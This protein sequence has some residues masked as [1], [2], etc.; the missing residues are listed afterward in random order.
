[1]EKKDCFSCKNK[2]CL[3]SQN[4]GVLMDTE[5]LSEKHTI[6]TKRNQNFMLEGAPIHGLFF[7]YT[8][9]VKVYKTGINGREQILRFAK[10]GEIIGH[11]GFTIGEYHEVSAKTLDETILCNFPH[12]TL[13][14]MLKSIPELTFSFM[15]FFSEEL[16]R[17]E[18]KVQKFAQMNVREKVIDTLLYLNRKFGQTNGFLNIVLSRKEIA[19]YAGTTDEQVIRMLSALKKEQ[20]IHSKGKSIGIRNLDCLK[21]EISDHMFFISS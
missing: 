18:T 7:V 2:D 6:F 3:I 21:S 16:S 13:L 10:D 20:L 15:K 4:L 14:K 19:D 11:R 9:K 17:S 5:F 12:S 8:G 1:M